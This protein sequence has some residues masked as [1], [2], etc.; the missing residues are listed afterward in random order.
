MGR[1]N[2]VAI[3]YYELSL[4]LFAETM[5]FGLRLRERAIDANNSKNSKILRGPLWVPCRCPPAH[6]ETILYH[7]KVL[8]CASV[9]SASLN[10]TSSTSGCRDMGAMSA[11]AWTARE[12]MYVALNPSLYV[13]MY[14]YLT[15]SH[16]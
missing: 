14:S 9:S 13:Q 11:Q 5:S 1:L 10:G 16:G 7:K 8:L 12:L 6:I 4:Q 3:Q 2:S 15:D